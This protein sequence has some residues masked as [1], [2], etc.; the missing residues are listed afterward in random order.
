MIGKKIE[1]SLIRFLNNSAN[2]DDLDA[3]SKWL[4]GASNDDVFKDFIKSHFALTIGMNDPDSSEIKKRLLN[5]IRKDKNVLHTKT[6]LSVFKY[7]AIIVT[8]VG[9]GYFLKQ[10]QANLSQDAAKIQVSDNAKITLELHDGKTLTLGEDGTSEI[11]NSTG[12]TVGHQEGRKLSYKDISSIK[13]LQYNTLKVPYGKHF[14]LVLSDGSKVYLNSGSSLRYPIKFLEGFERRVFLDGE[15][16]FEVS[17]DDMDSFEVSAQELNVRV[18]G[19]KFNLSNYPEDL[20][21]E[22]VLTDG[23]VRLSTDTS[24][25]NNPEGVYLKPGFKGAFNRTLK[26]ISTKK[27]NTSLYTSWVDGNLIFRKA[28]FERIIRKLERQYNVVIIN[29]N[30]E[31]AKETFNAT[32]ETNRETIEEVFDYFGKVYDIEYEYINNKIIIN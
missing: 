5:E 8:L 27:V 15:A 4:D 20:N 13:N 30:D 16:F 17:H 9:F 23:S 31:L 10:E 22:V 1:N 25:P 19:T 32:I 28:T 14:D 3:L 21:T 26:T 24:E 6:I 11:T 29:N 12:N 18:Y 7:A 2:K